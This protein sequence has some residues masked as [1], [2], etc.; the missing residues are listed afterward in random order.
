MRAACGGSPQIEVVAVDD[1]YPMGAE[2]QLITSLTGREVPSGGLPADVGV[3]CQNTGSAYA[4]FRAVVH[5]EPVID[6]VVT[7]SGTGLAEPANLRV[8]IGTPL[9]EVAA[10]CGGYRGKAGR[11]I[12]GGPMV[13][14]PLPSDAPPVVKETNGF[15][16]QSPAELARDEALPCIRCGACVEACPENLMPNDMYALARNRDLDK[17]QEYDLFDC[18][19]CGSCAYVCPSNLPLVQYYRFAKGEIQKREREKEHA[20]I[21]RRRSEARE[22]R[23]AREKAE[24]EAK[25]KKKKQAAADKEERAEAARQAAEQK[26]GGQQRSQEAGD[27]IHTSEQEES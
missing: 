25:R 27:G 4:A 1:N 17:I 12:L 23:L 13:G 7:A 14:S 26:S 8:R 9:F 2:R 5:G 24:K 10:A 20:E 3:L 19:E 11:M 16:V 18:I 21:A 15:I 22:A 6:R